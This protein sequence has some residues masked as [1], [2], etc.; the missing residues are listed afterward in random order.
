MLS[1]TGK[2]FINPS[3]IVID[4]NPPKF[5]TCKCSSKAVVSVVSVILVSSKYLAGPVPTGKIIAS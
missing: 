3:G 2:L 1:P 5:P 4:G